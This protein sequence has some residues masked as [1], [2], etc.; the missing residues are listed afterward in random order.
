M[1]TRFAMT[2]FVMRASHVFQMGVNEAHLKYIGY[3]RYKIR[4]C[5]TRVHHF[6]RIQKGL[7]KKMNR[8]SQVCPAKDFIL[9][10]VPIEEN[11][12]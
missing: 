8:V 9:F 10:L 1:N 2:C 6:S 4:H 12:P 5:K 11:A 7:T 3:S